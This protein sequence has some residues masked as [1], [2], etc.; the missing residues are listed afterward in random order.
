MSATST[1]WDPES[2]SA[3]YEEINGLV[4][5]SEKERVQGCVAQ[6]IEASPNAKI[7]LVTVIRKALNGYLIWHSLVAQP[8][9]WRKT[10]YVT[11]TTL[12]KMAPFD[13]S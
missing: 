3:F 13:N 9:R 8:F 4:K 5:E 6:F 2:V 7:V 10:L 11:L 12:G 1:E